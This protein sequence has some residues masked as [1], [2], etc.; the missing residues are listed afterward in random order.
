MEKEIDV[1]LLEHLQRIEVISG[2]G[3]VKTGSIGYVSYF[4]NATKNR[5]DLIAYICFSRFGKGG[6]P[7]IT[8]YSLRTCMIKLDNLTEAERSKV[9]FTHSNALFIKPAGTGIR[10]IR[11]LPVYE[12]VCYLYAFST[13]L[14]RMEYLSTKKWP[15]AMS[16]N[17][18]L[19]RIQMGI[20]DLSIL[21]FSPFMSCLN[22]T[23]RMDEYEGIIS[24]IIEHFNNMD[25]RSI[26]M[27]KAH[28]VFASNKK[29]LD[30]Y[31]AQLH[32]S[33]ELCVRTILEILYPNKEIQL[34]AVA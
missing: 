29:I 9:S 2:V 28:K 24:Y 7:R 6:K 5:S 11:N 17:D 13:F 30:T 21:E 26:F 8:P 14:G 15:P 4:D 34:K 23:L 31:L 33:Y 19:D 3:S 22:S 16:K 20:N 12:F 18:M 10:D 25:N 27:D 1:V 32:S